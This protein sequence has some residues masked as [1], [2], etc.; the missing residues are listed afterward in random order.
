MTVALERPTTAPPVREF[1]VADLGP[2]EAHMRAMLPEVGGYDPRLH[3]DVDD[4]VGTYLA[5]P[6]R[7]LLVSTDPDGTVLGTASVRPGG[8]NPAY[9]PAW[10]TERYAARSVG[11]VCRVWVAPTARRRGVGQGLARAAVTWAR[12]RFDVVCLHTNASVPGALAFWRAFPGLV[13]V[14]DARPDPYSTVH[15]EVCASRR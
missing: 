11:Q 5:R 10:L 7:V 12:S 4:V 14:F 2:V 6:D 1:T 13:E 3:A 8:P 9:V 15:F